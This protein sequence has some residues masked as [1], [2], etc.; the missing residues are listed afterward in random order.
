MQELMADDHPWLH[1]YFHGPRARAAQDT[2][3]GTENT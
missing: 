1:D 3:A 2:V